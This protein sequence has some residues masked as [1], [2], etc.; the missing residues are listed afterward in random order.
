M[1]PFEPGVC[2][3]Q[4]LHAVMTKHQARKGSR[5]IS[6]REY[7]YF[8]N[9]MWGL[10]GDRTSGPAGTYYLSSAKP[11]NYF[12]NI[13]D[14]VLVRPELMDG[15]VDIRLLEYD[16]KVS[17]RTPDGVPRVSDHLPIYLELEL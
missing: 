6:G 3:A 2:G 12:W 10:F 13:Y 17:L 7:R 16:G 8:Y 1:N 15:I 4:G 14:Q 11:V 5:T 9:P